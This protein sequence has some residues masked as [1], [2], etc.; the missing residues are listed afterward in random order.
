VQLN[1]CRWVHTTVTQALQEER[2]RER[3]S[4]TARLEGCNALN[5]TRAFRCP[6]SVYRR[7]L[8]FGANVMP[9]ECNAVSPPATWIAKCRDPRLVAVVLLAILTSL[10]LSPVLF[11]STMPVA[12]SPA[13][14][15]QVFR[16]ETRRTL[17]QTLVPSV[18]QT[19]AASHT[20]SVS[21]TWRMSPVASSSPRV[22]VV[23]LRASLPAS[24]SR[25]ASLPASSKTPA[26]S[27]SS[28]SDATVALPNLCRPGASF[29]GAWSKHRPSNETDVSD[30]CP[31]GLSTARSSHPD[32]VCEG[33]RHYDVAVFRPARCDVLTIDESLAVITAQKP[34]IR[35]VHFLGDS[36]MLQQ[37]LA[38]HCE[39]SRYAAAAAPAT[40]LL[41]T[42]AHSFS[43]FL[44]GDLRCYPKCA[45]N[46]AFLSSQR[47]SSGHCIACDRKGKPLPLLPLSR[48]AWLRDLPANT[49]VLILGT[50]TWYSEFFLGTRNTAR[51]Y[52]TMLGIVAPALE[53][54]V[55]TRCICV[56]WLAIPPPPPAPGRPEFSWSTFAE[57]NAAA[58]KA[59]LQ[60][61]PSVIFLDAW[62]ALQQRRMSPLGDAFV[63]S[64][65][66]LHWCNPGR[67]T[68]PSWL[69]QHILHTIATGSCPRCSKPL[70]LAS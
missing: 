27:P 11:T 34:S 20:A 66:G 29:E 5:T 67:G 42:S 18:T 10:Q 69:T 3:E 33:R 70:P 50:G 57:K 32:Y 35:H 48:V 1:C 23:L 22:P 17:P 49:D 59:F 6:V 36:L 58:R 52:A 30:Y 46:A 47:K 68:I 41:P 39:L 63:S 4:G 9:G 2:E 38:W 56:I 60:H 26:P 16:N 37:Y 40:S 64:T 19:V 24:V 25:S 44:L 31:D 55:A 54:L 14:H 43:S 65:H 8:R 61:A 21:N 62:Q 51:L 45:R 53:S 7:W 12:P 28:A 13:P 15:L